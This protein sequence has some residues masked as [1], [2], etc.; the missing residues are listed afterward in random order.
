[1]AV[2]GGADSTALL[3][4]LHA[5]A[6]GLG[7]SL[8]VAH[9]DHALRP[10]SPA[11][12][13]HVRAL[14][15]ILAVPLSVTRV[16]VAALA[17]GRRGGLEETAREARRSFLRDTAQTHGCDWIALAHQRDDQVETFL[18][19][20]VARCG[21]DRPD[22]HA[23]VSTRP[24]SARCWRSPVHDLVEWLVEHGIAWRDDVS[25][26][27]LTFVRNRVR[28]ELLPLLERF[29]PAI[30]LRL[31]ELCRQLAD[32]EDGLGRRGL[33]RRWR[34]R[35]RAPLESCA[36]RAPLL[37][38]GVPGDGRPPG[39]CRAQEVRGYLRRLDAGHVTAILALA[40]ARPHRKGSCTSPA[41]GSAAATRPCAF[42]EKRRASPRLQPFVE[43]PAPGRYPLPDGR[44]PA[45]P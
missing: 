36:C 33:P 18:L 40:Q 8:H 4:L 30:R 2:S 35:S 9:L 14:C 39:A 29:N 27:D 3:H 6:P 25:N 34:T 12:A 31:A 22:R 17:Q 24:L 28:H 42:A 13:A 10:D 19:A 20:T 37:A 38:A 21:Y 1:M 44:M 15:A 45:S 32:D 23:F 16:D 43:I 7:L 41:A 11:D 26:R 5:A